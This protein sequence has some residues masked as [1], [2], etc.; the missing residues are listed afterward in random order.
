MAVQ[1]RNKRESKTSQLLSCYKGLFIRNFLTFN[2]SSPG[3]LKICPY[4]LLRTYFQTKEFKVQWIWRKN[5][6]FWPLT[7]SFP[8]ATKLSRL[9]F[10]CFGC[11]LVRSLW[12][13]LLHKGW[14]LEGAGFIWAYLWHLSIYKKTMTSWTTRL[15]V[16]WSQEKLFIQTYDKYKCL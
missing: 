14:T 11:R 7:L 16:C 12:R 13:A 1:H 9:S 8:Q 2:L 10:G 15:K 4:L 6:S 3:F 5:V